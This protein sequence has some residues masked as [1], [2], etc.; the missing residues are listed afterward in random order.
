MI[1]CP[2]PHDPPEVGIPT[3]VPT[4]GQIE[5][6]RL[7]ANEARR[8]L[9]GCGFTD[10]QILHWAETYIARHGSGDVECFVGWIHN[11]E[12]VI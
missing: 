1:T 2:I 8:F 5:G 12:L 4:L 9:I 6:A 11:P 3:E 10:A 7:L